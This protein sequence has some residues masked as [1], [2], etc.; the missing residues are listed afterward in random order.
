[1]IKYGLEKSYKSIDNW[2]LE[3]AEKVSSSLFQIHFP[4]FFLALFFLALPKNETKKSDSLKPVPPRK[5]KFPAIAQGH[6]T[7]T[8]V[9]LFQFR[10]E[11]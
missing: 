11:N 4:L 9:Q 10:M 2:Y 5:P 7:S 8:L 6:E 1:M 3:T